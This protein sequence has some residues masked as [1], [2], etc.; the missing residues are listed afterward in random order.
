MHIGID[1]GTTNSVLAKFDGK[2]VTIVPNS[3]GEN[4]T[5]SVVRIDGRGAAS[6][7][8]RAFRFLDSEWLRFR[9]SVERL[10][11]L[12]GRESLQ[13]AWHDGVEFAAWN[14]PYELE[15]AQGPRATWACHVMYVWVAELAEKVGDEEAARVNRNNA[16]ITRED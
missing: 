9:E 10:E 7:G 3:L 8:R 1:L 15:K 6:V 2:S 13:T 5:P 14:W 12:A 11:A 16:K 4:L